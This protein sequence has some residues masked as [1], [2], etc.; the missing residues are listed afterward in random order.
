[1]EPVAIP[2]TE[3]N[4]SNAVNYVYMLS[5]TIRMIC[6]IDC[7]LSLFFF[8]FNPYSL[9]YS[10]ILLAFSYLGYNGAKTFNKFKLIPYI[11]L[12]LLKN[13]ASVYLIFN[14]REQTNFVIFESIYLLLS[15][16]ITYVI[17][18]FYIKLSGLDEN[19]LDQ[20]R[21]YNRAYIVTVI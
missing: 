21:N 3:N 15:A 2:I 9:F 17:I 20:V 13:I 5:R 6:I 16:Y 8:M 18:K 12:N 7:F 19:Q 11:V 4:N 14:F 10:L 1:M